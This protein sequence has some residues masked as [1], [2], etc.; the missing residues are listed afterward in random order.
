MSNLQHIIKK[1]CVTLTSEDSA[2]QSKRLFDILCI[3]VIIFDLTLFPLE[4]VSSFSTHFKQILNLQYA[5]I[6]IFTMEY[7]I[8]IIGAKNKWQFI[9]SFYGVIDFLA[10]VP[11]V[12]TYGF[13]NTS[14]FR[15]VRL[16]RLFRILKLTRYSKSVK[17]LMTAIAEIKVELLTILTIAFF[18]VYIFSALIYVLEHSAQPDKVAN[19]F[20]AFWLTFVTVTTLGYGDITPITAG[21]RI[22]T[23]VFVIF[24]I[25]IVIM[26]SSVLTAH[27]MEKRKQEMN[28][29][30]TSL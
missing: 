22:L 3:S 14:Y 2:S 23:I 6:F 4:T 9:T 27:L 1:L 29:R 24:S 13:V 26:P 18:V 16:I 17:K 21:G 5:I 25:G 12:L 19:M 11:F 8:R 7:F 20:D 30:E 28:Q 15:I 10:I